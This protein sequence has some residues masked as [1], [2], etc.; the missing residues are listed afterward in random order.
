[1][2]GLCSF[3]E[4]ENKLAEAIQLSESLKR[5]G[6][7]RISTM[8]APH[9]PYT[10]PPAFLEMIVSEAKSKDL[11]IHIHLSETAKEVDEHVEQYGKRPAIHLAELGVF[12]VHTLIAHGVHLDD[13]EME[14]LASKG[15]AVSH[16]PISNLKLGSGIA[17]VPKMLNKDILV[18]LGTDSAAS[19]NNL[20]MFQEMR[21]AA[22]IHKG[23][24][25][26]A[27]VVSAEEVL[28]MATNNGARAL[29][30]KKLGVIQRGKEADFIV[31][32]SQKP[33]LQPNLHVTSH[34]VYSASGSDVL[35]VY[36]KGNCLVRNGQCLSLDEEKIVFEANR[37]FQNLLN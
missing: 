16:N 15:V 24:L 10:C 6:D 18:G 29:A 32:D 27:T 23:N 35:D 25:E 34:I 9:A 36:V 33:H 14:V 20:D 11:P 2:I 22:L 8:L 21:I 17:N 19:N 26:N 31:I 4:Q 7:G 28:V 3:N 37:A 30:L 12:D 5:F 13:Q 1:M